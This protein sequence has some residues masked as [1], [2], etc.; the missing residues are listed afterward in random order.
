MLGVKRPYQG[1]LMKKA[2]RPWR[3]RLFLMHDP[4]GCIG[5]VVTFE[6]P[7]NTH[8]SSRGEYEHY[9]V[10]VRGEEFRSEHLHGVPAPITSFCLGDEADL[11]R[12]AQSSIP[13]VRHKGRGRTLCKLWCAEGLTKR[14][15][16]S[17]VYRFGVLCIYRRCGNDE[18]GLYLG[19]SKQ[20]LGRRAAKIGHGSTSG[21]HEI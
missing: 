12:D 7:Q 15:W 3:Q 13:L 16:K 20:N 19:N 14:N 17:I 5:V 4:I 8:S 1:H 18:L 21:N 2:S 9:F 6:V 11:R 10:H